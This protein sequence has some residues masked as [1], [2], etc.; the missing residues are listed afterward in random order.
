[1][2]LFIAYHMIKTLMRYVIVA[3]ARFALELVL[4]RIVR[5]KSWYMHLV[6]ND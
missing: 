3:I 6:V 2:I 4:Y 1:M 5:K